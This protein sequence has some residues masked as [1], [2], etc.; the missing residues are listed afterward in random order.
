MFQAL[1]G[2]NACM[3][4]SKSVI[5]GVSWQTFLRIL[6]AVIG[7]GKIA[8]L[9]RILSP[10]EIGLFSLVAIA[11]GLSEASTQTGVNVTILQSKQSIRY[12]LDTAWVIAII[13]GVI[14]GCSMVVLGIIM[15]SYYQEPSLQLLVALTATVPIIKGC[16]NPSIVLYQKN[17]QFFKDALFKL[18]I[19]LAEVLIV[20]AFGWWFHSIYIL[21]FSLIGAALVEVALSFIVFPDKPRFRYLPSRAA[22]IFANAKG[23]TISSILN[24]INENADDLIIGKV[25]GTQLLGIYHNGYS[26]SHK[27]NL[28][29]GKVIH[30]GTMPVFAR[31]NHDAVRLKA[32][33]LRSSIASIVLTGI[34]SLPLFI[35]PE[36]LVR[37]V[38]GPTWL[39]VA[40]LLPWLG[41]AGML[42]SFSTISYGL[43]LATAHYKALNMHLGATALSMIPLISMLASWDGIR[44]AVIGLLLSRLI[45][46]P[47]I[48]VGISMALKKNNA[49]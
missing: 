21:I 20:F 3:G 14:I 34:L 49:I 11:L 13:R 5:S 31:I 17:L 19:S 28:E 18:A 47:I 1:N 33:F 29:I 10:A 2:D 23:L 26:L 43:L 46:L 15:T 8:F 32:A 6:T 48:L 12:F 42:Q 30:N 22:V 16:I 38:L 27:P 41:L 7:L 45:T 44:G 35:M 36:L 4:Y 37:I 24:Y 9:A 40:P 25:L 39:A